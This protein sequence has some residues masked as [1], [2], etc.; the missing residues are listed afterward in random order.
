MN[1]LSSREAFRSM[2]KK[3]TSVSLDEALVKAAKELNLNVS[4]VANEALKEAIKVMAGIGD[5]RKIKSRALQAQLNSLLARR[6]GLLEE[7]HLID[8]EIE[9]IEA[10][11][12]RKEEYL[13]EEDRSQE[14]ASIM[15][16]INVE[17][18]KAGF[19]PVI[20]WENCESLI[21]RLESLKSP[22]DYKRFEEHVQLLE[23]VT[24]GV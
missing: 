21:L 4:Y 8:S 15:K 10:M 5:P 22:M 24:G 23:K 19:D 18:R 6:A 17:I 2:R 1:S 12:A 20:A 7:L 14:I 3:I 11:L 13:E 9:K 16:G